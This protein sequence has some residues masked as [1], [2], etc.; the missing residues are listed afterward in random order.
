MDVGR[1]WTR[2]AAAAARIAGHIATGPL[3]RDY[4]RSWGATAQEAATDWP[5]HPAGRPVSWSVTHAVTIDAPV[6]EVWPWLAQLGQGRGGLYSFQRL[7]NLIGCRMTNTDRILPEHQDLAA[8]K[9]VRLHPQAVLPVA[10]LEP[11]RDLVLAASPGP[12]TT[13][14]RVTGGVWSFHLRDAPGG[15]T[16]LVERLDL[17]AGPTW[18]E[19][20]FTAPA[21]MEPISFVMSQEMLR[22]IQRLAAHDTDHP[23]SQRTTMS[24]TQPK[25]WNELTRRQQTAVLALAGV[26]LSLAATAW[27]DLIRRPAEQVNGRKGI[28]AAII[29]V[30][31]LGP[32]LYFSRGIRC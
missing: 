16:R 12:S 5:G 2:N 14:Q 23:S 32:V 27:T 24:S 18:Q 25:K 4:R 15:R 21:L 13:D 7:E 11:G 19:K 26:Q 10:H 8:V 9:E 3:L 20:L 28:W 6:E 31:F 1:S 30:N 29:A 17:S 22:N